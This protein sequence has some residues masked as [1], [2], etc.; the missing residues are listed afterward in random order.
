VIFTETKLKGAYIIDVKKLE[1]ERG[2]FG[3]SWCK[4]EFEAHGLNSN[5]VQAN[6]SYNIRKGTLRGMHYQVAPYS[7]TKTI[8][9]TSGAIYDVIVDIRPE[10]ETYRQWIGV[11]LTA[12]SFRML[13]VPE[14]FAHGFI[15]LKDHTSVHYMVTQY[16]TP[17][18]EGGLRYDD[19]AFNIEWPIKPEI[20]SEKD[21][22]HKPYM[23]ETVT[24]NGLNIK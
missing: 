2:F 7:E 10:S 1:D 9:C 19:P 8:R 16:Y 5:A 21:Q 11:E 23:L 12:E 14:G 18:A 3:R 6:V 15:T 24:V 17:G 4:H 13:Y 20:V 22:N